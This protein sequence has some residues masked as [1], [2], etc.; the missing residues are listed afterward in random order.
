MIFIIRSDGDSAKKFI[1]RLHTVVGPSKVSYF[2]S[3]AEYEL[4]FIKQ[5][6][7]NPSKFTV[8]EVHQGLSIAKVIEYAKVYEEYFNIP[9]FFGRVEDLWQ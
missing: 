4:K 1:D 8:V 7:V 2:T 6:G 5:N 3:C 9:V